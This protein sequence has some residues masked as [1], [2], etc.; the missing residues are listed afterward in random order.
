M[1]KDAE[2]LMQPCPETIWGQGISDLVVCTCLLTPLCHLSCL[3]LSVSLSL[4]PS[5]PLSLSPSLPPSLPLS[6]LL[7]LI[8]V[9]LCLT[10]S[11]SSSSSPHAS[12]PP[13]TTPPQENEHSCYR[14]LN[15]KICTQAEQEKLKASELPE[16]PTFVHRPDNVVTPEDEVKFFAD[17]KEMLMQKL[18]D[19][20]AVVLKGFKTTGEPEVG[21]L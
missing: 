2:S 11:S 20:G 4:S 15:L 9:S 19:H 14:H 17:N 6:L 8:Q 16:F 7:S 5:L 1:R 3:L 18:Q 13:P 12:N 21:V 10:S